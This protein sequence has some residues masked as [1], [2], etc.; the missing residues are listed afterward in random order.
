MTAIPT[1]REMTADSFFNGRIHVKQDR[2]GYRFSIDAVI[3]AHHVQPQPEDTLID[4]GT[5]CAIIPLILAYRHPDIRIRGIEIQPSLAEIARL[6]VAENRLQAQIDIHCMDLRSLDHRLLATPADI[7]TANPPFREKQSGRINPNR[8]SAVA[9]H[10]IETT[11]AEVVAAACRLLR[12][13][14]RLMV[15][16]SADRT[17][18]LLCAMRSAGIE[19]KRCRMV[20]SKR[21]GRARLVLVEGIKG[22]RPG[23]VV[24]APLVIYNKDASYTDEIEAM[25]GP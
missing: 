8:Q 23:I 19:P 16:Y 18:D 11:L 1:K 6:N 24:T 7:V 21:H 3:L 5:G 20:H 13:G 9:R 15:V 22:A 2:R 10:E 14:G 4:L 17:T 25:F 12:K